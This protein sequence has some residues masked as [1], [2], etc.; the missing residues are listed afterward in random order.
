MYQLDCTKPRLPEFSFP[1][2]LGHREGPVVVRTVKV[3]QKP[4]GTTGTLSPPAGSPGP[5][6]AVAR[7]VTAP[8]SPGSFFTVLVSWTR[9]VCLVREEEPGFCRMSIIK[10]KGSVNGWRFQPAL[11]G[12]G[13]HIWAVG[14]PGSPPLYIH[15]P[16]RWS[17]CTPQAPDSPVE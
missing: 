2:T 16:S 7:P 13:S 3:K 17:P 14:S 6:E 8:P 9:R 12:S 5:G 10:T 15:L 4:F 1:V 11:V